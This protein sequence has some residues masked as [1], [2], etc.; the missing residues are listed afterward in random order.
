MNIIGKPVYKVWATNALRFGNVVE[1]KIKD[2]WKYVLVDWK[3][4]EAYEMDIQRVVELRNIKYDKEQ[5]WYRIDRVK[6]F[7]PLKMVE[8]LGKVYNERAA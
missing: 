7:D 2:D 1:E 5:E 6:F 3:D 4:D 8:T